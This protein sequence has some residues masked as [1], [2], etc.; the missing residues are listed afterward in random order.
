[1]LLTQKYCLYNV[2]MCVCVC[3]C[4]R[5]V[6]WYIYLVLLIANR[7]TDNQYRVHI[8]SDCFRR[9]LLNRVK[10]CLTQQY[11]HCF[12]WP[13]EFDWHQLFSFSN[14]TAMKIPMITL[15]FLIVCECVCVSFANEFP[16]NSLARVSIFDDK[17]TV[18]DVWCSRFD[19]R[20]CWF[21]SLSLALSLFVHTISIIVTVLFL[22]ILFN[23]T[24]KKKFAK[25]KTVLSRCTPHQNGTIEWKIE[26]CRV[27]LQI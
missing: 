18:V 20:S 5:M 26:R 14:S 15:P 13:C 2:C 24:R 19:W 23:T 3:T 12:L 10:T 22:F 4:V 6:W 1:M 16:F 9:Q 21:F 8:E 25:K 7:P 11:L 27:F 17:Q